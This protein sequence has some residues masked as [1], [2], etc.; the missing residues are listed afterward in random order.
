[1]WHLII[2]TYRSAASNMAYD[3]AL[4]R[5]Q[6]KE[7]TQSPVPT[8]RVYGWDAPSCSFGYAQR[9]KERQDLLQHYHDHC[10]RRPTGG[11]IVEHAFDIS[12]SIVARIPNDIIPDGL[13]HSFTWFHAC[14]AYGLRCKGFDVSFAA[15]TQKQ[16]EK[17][18]HCFAQPVTSDILLEQKKVVGS[19]QRRSRTVL[20]Q[21][22]TIALPDM[23][24]RDGSLIARISEMFIAGFAGYGSV[25]FQKRTYTAFETATAH[26]LEQ[27][28]HDEA[29][30]IKI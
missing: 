25:S 13:V 30:N 18:Y 15:S 7:N 14:I 6:E 11:G 23:L 26:T 27:K 12:Y 10:V 2:D 16:R 4:M 17:S 19:A 8:V 9:M 21:Q 1:M 28:Y 29:W 20:L 5:A 3:E 22:G 24:S